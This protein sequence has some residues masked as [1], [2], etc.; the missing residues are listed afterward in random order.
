MRQLTRDLADSKDLLA[1]YEHYYSMDLS[2]TIPKP[3]DARVAQ[4]E[5]WID[6]SQ[7]LLDE[8]KDLSVSEQLLECKYSPIYEKFFD[9]QHAS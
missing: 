4:E 3:Q 7:F 8:S 6:V 5:D 2:S 9:Q 1:M